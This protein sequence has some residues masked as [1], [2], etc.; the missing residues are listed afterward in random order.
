MT[1]LG[2]V[3]GSPTLA[4]AAKTDYPSWQD[5]QAAKA[6]QAAKQAEITKIQG[7]LNGLEAQA[8]AL[9]K[10]ALEKGEL[11]NQ[12][13]DALD[14]ATKKTDRLKSQA[15]AAQAKADKSARR[16]SALIAQLAQTGGGNITLGV[17]F[18]SAS[19]ADQLLAN[20]GTAS[21]LSET[22]V[23]LLKKAQFDKNTA[24][25]LVASAKVAEK[26]RVALAGDAQ[27]ALDAAQKASD[28]AQSQ[29]A[30]QQAAQ[31]TMYAQLASLKNTTASIEQQYEAGVAWEA[32]QNAKSTP[33]SAPVINPNP[34]APVAGAVAGAIAFA[35]AQLGK[36]YV[37]GGAGPSTWDC[38]GL[39]LVS[40]QVVG[41]YIGTHSATN[42]YNYMASH[43]RLV[44]IN[45]LQAGDLLYYSD[46]GSTTASKYHTTIYIGGGQ[47]IE[48]PYPGV[49]VRIK[50]VRYGDLVPYAGRP[51]G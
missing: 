6:N 41:V 33:P 14:A 35:K 5:V 10:V 44:N 27:T 2:L 43:G 25:S 48:A 34:S 16:A 45:Q 28:A 32:A 22:S 36:P 37:L 42:Q 18:G 7:I 40:Y 47:M 49:T 39:T 15:D 23:Q 51:T 1:A 24:S 13:R 50:P 9:G 11:Y 46:G 3:A 30:Q 29:L 8:A 38:S 21:R 19:Q 4:F 31:S 26:Q 12:A 17:L 20:L